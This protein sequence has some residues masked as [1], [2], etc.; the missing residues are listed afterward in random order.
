MPVPAIVLKHQPVNG[1][2]AVNLEIENALCL[3]KGQIAVLHQIT[4]KA[5][6]AFVRQLFYDPFRD[7]FIH[8][9]GPKL[10]ILLYLLAKWIGAG[11]FLGTEY[12]TYGLAHIR[13]RLRQNVVQHI[14]YIKVV[15]VKGSSVD[16]CQTAELRHGYFGIGFDPQKLFA[17]KYDTF[18]N[19]FRK[20]FRF[21]TTFTI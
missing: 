19:R 17:A 8:K 1:Q 18:L 3:F 7:G 14:I 2:T 12:M 4:D 5:F 16:V 20:L 6:L 11:F 15:D 13:E 21:C 9:Q 10:F